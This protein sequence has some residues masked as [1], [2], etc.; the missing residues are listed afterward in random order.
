MSVWRTILLAINLVGVRFAGA[1]IG[2]ASQI[3]LAR[4]LTQNQVGIIFMGMSAAAFVSLII[5]GGYPQLAITCLPRYYTLG[6]TTLVQAFHAAFLRDSFWITLGTFAIATVAYFF[7]GLDEGIKTA[8]LFGCL[9]APAS[10][11]IRMNSSVANSVRR[12]ALSYVPD[13]LYRPGLLLGFLLIA[14]GVGL[15]LSV[16]QVLW[17]FVLA[18]TAVAVVQAILIGNKGARSGLKWS[19]R[20]NLAPFL[21]SRAGALVIVGIVA[22]SFAD[23]VTLLAG[24]FL[25]AA[26]VAL[27]GVTIRLAALAGFI[28]Q[29]SQQFILPDLTNAMTH[30]TPKQVHSLLLR[31]NAISLGAILACVLGAVVFGAFALKVFGAGYGLGHWPLVLFMVSQAF[32]AAS[33]MNQ[34]LLSLAGHQIKTAGSCIVAMVVL[35][36]TT[37]IL[38][39]RFGVMGISFAV[40]AADAVWAILLALQAQ[41]LTGH[42]GDIIGVLSDRQAHAQ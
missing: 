9:S 33:G 8:L 3:L 11:A 40:I 29:A 30:G 2:L 22:A 19:G 4:L 18:N 6:R 28:T 38:T 41:R 24:F 39:P 31:I 7:L 21:R 14:W 25:D 1:A 34:Y 20:H 42:R 35:V 5:T 13:F 10:A 32:R 16:N 17:A 15:Q 27:V 36:A 26:D 37:A 23:I 12:Y